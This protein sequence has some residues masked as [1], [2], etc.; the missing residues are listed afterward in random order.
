MINL[1]ELKKE[2]FGPWDVKYDDKGKP[3]SWTY[4]G[5]SSK[6]YTQA[7]QTYV[8][9]QLNNTLEKIFVTGGGH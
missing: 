9:A 3:I 1:E 4:L 7:M 5:P 2:L 6:D 8:L